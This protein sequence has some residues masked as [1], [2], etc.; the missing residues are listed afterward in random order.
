MAR[1]K[2]E[3]PEKFKFSTEITV[4]I[5]DINYGGHLGND[6]F[7]SLIHEARIRFLNH[8][9]FAEYDAGGSGII[10]IDSVI[11]YKS[12]IFY[13]DDLIVDVTAGD[14]WKYGC[15]IFYRMISKKTGSDAIIAK[16][17]IIFFDYEKRQKVR[18]PNKFLLHFK[19]NS[20]G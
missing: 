10:L 17:G 7:L 18:T 16:T 4:R 12:E 11:I 9:G 2:I 13:G 5:S 8:Y 20:D 6:T 15:D 19:S 14:F 1:I 3:L